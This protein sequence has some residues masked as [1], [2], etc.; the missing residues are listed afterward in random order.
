MNKSDF[1]KRIAGRLDLGV[2]H[3]NALYEAIME[4]AVSCLASG[5]TVPLNN[6]GS[7]VIRKRGPRVGRNPATGEKIDIPA[8]SS[9][10]FRASSTI[11]RVINNG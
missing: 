6:I 7:L 3:A 11:K 1:V 9:V 8:K 4:E 5:E 10:G 2:T